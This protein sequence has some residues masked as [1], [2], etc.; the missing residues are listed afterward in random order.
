MRKILRNVVDQILSTKKSSFSIF[1]SNKIQGHD[2][3]VKVLRK[4]FNLDF[5]YLQKYYQLWR[6]KKNDLIKKDNDF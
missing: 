2:K 5:I 3:K 6:M 1:K 4:A